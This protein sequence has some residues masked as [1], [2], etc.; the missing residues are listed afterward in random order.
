M[1]IVA[2]AAD[3]DGT[4][5]K[6]GAIYPA[7]LEIL[8]QL[9]SSGRRTILVTGRE[10]PDLL[11]LLPDPRIFDLIVAENGALLYRPETAE[12]RLLTDPPPPQLIQKL[13]ESGVAPLSIGRGIIATW[14]PHQERVFYAIHELGLEHQVIFNKGAVMVLP[15]GINKGTGFAAALRELDISPHNAV[16]VGDAENDH[17]LLSLAEYGVAVSN[18]LPTVKERADI[19]TNLDHGDGVAEIG[20]RVLANDLADLPQPPRRKQLLLGYRDDDSPVTLPSRGANVLIAG[21][22]ESGKSSLAFGLLER[23]ITTSYQCCVLDPEGDYDSVPDTVAVG[24]ETQ[25]PTN[26]AVAA[27]LQRPEPSIVVNALNVPFGDRPVFFRALMLEIDELRRSFGRPH[28]LLVDEAHHML[29]S[30]RPNELLGVPCEPGGT[31]LVTLDPQ[32]VAPAALDRVDIVIATGSEPA[33]IMR[34]FAAITGAGPAPAIERPL[35]LGEAMVWWVREQRAETIRIETSSI[36]HRRHRRKYAHGHVGPERCFYF[37]GPHG[38]YNLQAPNLVS[39]VQ[40]GEQID[41]D[42]WRFHL[43]RGD[44][45]RW[46]RSVIRDDE[47]V[48][49][50]LALQADAEAPTTELRRHLRRAI[51]S[52]YILQD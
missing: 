17:A 25:A 41:D 9:K 16:A 31:I 8:A 22:P 11:P 36:P 35:K 4:L 47:L 5:A 37:R 44:Y 7:A 28:W 34:S 43:N 23:S 45:A 21:P 52:R 48:S 1:Y 10:L 51:E 26:A 42:A 18:A 39:F 27:L 50:T 38:R 30:W 32:F 40:L 49:E 12:Q 15:P 24:D 14:E 46:F 2:F 6:D 3:F 19:V 20:R 29:P 13:R 33:T